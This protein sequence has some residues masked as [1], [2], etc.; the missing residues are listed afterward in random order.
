MIAS[1]A[2]RGE[3]LVVP[4]DNFPVDAQVYLTFY[5]TLSA[6]WPQGCETFSNMQKTLSA[7]NCS[8]N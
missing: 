5:N 8:E 3:Q 4:L 6:V 1:K 7:V 2:G